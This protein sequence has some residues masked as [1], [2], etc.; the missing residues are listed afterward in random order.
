MR[1]PDVCPG[2]CVHFAPLTQVS[3]GPA[4]ALLT[5][6]RAR[7]HAACW[8]LEGLRDAFPGVRQEVAL[9]RLLRDVR[10]EHHGTVLQ[11][12]ADLLQAG[13][14]LLTVAPRPGGLDGDEEG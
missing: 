3:F 9:P 5:L 7:R 10:P 4:A 11:A 2:G 8:L 14:L 13:A 12:V 6:P 1:A